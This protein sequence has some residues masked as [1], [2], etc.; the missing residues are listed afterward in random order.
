MCYLLSHF[1]VPCTY[2]DIRLVD[3]STSFEGRVEICIDETYGTVCDDFWNANDAEV[4]CRQIGYF[5][6]KL[7]HNVKKLDDVLSIYILF[8]M[9]CNIITHVCKLH[10]IF[11]F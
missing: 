2:G 6:G 1:L 5:G 10:E 9:G 11:I 3:G 8:I 7:I 4:V